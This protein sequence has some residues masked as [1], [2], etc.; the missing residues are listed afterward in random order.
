MPFKRKYGRQPDELRPCKITRKFLKTAPGAVLIECGDTK[1]ICTASVVSGVPPFLN[2]DRDGWLTSEYGMLPGSTNS[3]KK[4]DRDSR[5]TEIQRLIGRAVRAIVDRSKWPGY[6]VYLD[7]DVIQADGGT[8]TAS[9][10]GA[11]VALVDAV[12]SMEKKGALTG[13]PLLDSIA[14]ISVGIIDKTLLLDLNY[15]EDSNAEVD[16]NIVMTGKG[17]LVEV[18]GTAEKGTFSESQLTRLVKLARKG[19]T[20]L[21]VIQEGSLKE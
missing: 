7:C 16:M 4:R 1:V 20:E 11:Y 5:G 21:A 13:W 17:R 19:I 8:R 3:R 12:R 10:T 14:A 6:T 2:P 18:Q 9:I 15:A